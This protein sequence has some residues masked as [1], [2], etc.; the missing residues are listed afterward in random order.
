[1]SDMGIPQGVHPQDRSGVDTPIGPQ[2]QPAIYVTAPAP[3]SVS[4]GDALPVFERAA[5]HGSAMTV[6]VSSSAGGTSRAVGYLKGRKAVLM[7]VPS[8]A[9]NGVMVDFIQGRLQSGGGVLLAPG[10]SLTLPTEASIYVG[11]PSGASTASVNVIELYNGGI[12]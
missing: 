2:D 3:F 9:A 7:W 4:N 1:M 8:T 10:D 11:L 12:E 6:P 5:R